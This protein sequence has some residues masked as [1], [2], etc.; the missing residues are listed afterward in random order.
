[1]KSIGQLENSDSF[2]GILLA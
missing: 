1:M 2:S